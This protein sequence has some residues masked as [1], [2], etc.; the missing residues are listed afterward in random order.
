VTGGYVYRGPVS[1]FQG[2]YFFAD[3]VN[4]N[5]YSGRFDPSTNPASFNGTNLTNVQ[6]HTA[7]FEARLGGGAN[8]QYLTSFGEDNSGNLYLVK[9]GNGFFPPLGQGEIFRIS[10]ILSS[11]ITLEINRSSG[12]IT[13]ANATGTDV[14]F[15]ALT[16]TSAFGAIDPGA[17][18]PITGH[19]DESGNGAIDADDSWSVTSPPGSFTQFSEASTGDPG[20][21]A[22]GESIVLSPAGG[23]IRSPNEDL[24]VSLLLGDG[25]VLNASVR[26]TGNGGTPFARSDLDFNG[27]VDLADWSLFVAS[28]YAALTGLSRAE[29]YSRGDLDADG[30]NDHADFLLFKRD[31]N[32]ANGAGAFESRLL[33]VPERTTWGLAVG[34]A[35]CLLTAGRWSRRQPRVP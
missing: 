23:W 15:S 11:M 1:E 3:F 6:N 16:L 21:I 32:T 13:L 14:T 12:A 18:T 9:F 8:I 24:F 30:D 25:T 27:A 35:A 5:V 34:F 31:Y 7:D 17:L 26:Y 4:G 2:R 10:P 33:R 28:S 29:A 22:A 20:A 19:Y